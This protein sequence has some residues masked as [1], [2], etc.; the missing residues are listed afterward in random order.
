MD[1]VEFFVRTALQV[2]GVARERCASN[3]G[4]VSPEIESE[5]ASGIG[6]YDIA[7]PNSEL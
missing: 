4:E 3:V 2:A 7:A 6:P 5:I 1:F